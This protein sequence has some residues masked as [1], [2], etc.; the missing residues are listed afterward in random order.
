MLYRLIPLIFFI[1][2]FAFNLN[3]QC[4]IDVLLP[5]SDTT[6]CEGDSVHLN[7]D[8][9]CTFLMNN[10]FDNQTI[11]AGWYSTQANP[12]F[13][14]PCG[15]GPN[16]AHL[17]VGTTNS[18]Q[19]TLVTNNYDVSST[20]CMIKW[21]MRYGEISG[22]GSCEDPDLPDEGVHLQY[23]TNNGATWT[24]F[25]GPDVDPVGVNSF[26]PPFT[27][28]TTTVG[29]GGY[30]E[31]VGVPP[32]PPS[33]SVYY[34]HRYENS[35]PAAAATTNTKFRWAQLSTSNVNYDAWGIDE[36][37]IYCPG[38]Q[39]VAWSH[40]VQAFDG[41]WVSPTS[42]HTYT[43][44]ILDTSGNSASDDVTITVIPTPE[45]G[46]GP[47]TTICAGPNNY[48]V[49]QADSGYDTYLWNTGA[50][51]QSITVS[52]SG[53]YTV[54]VTDGNCSA[55]DSVN[56][57]VAPTPN[58]DAGPD[59]EICFGDSV[60]LTAAAANGSYAWS[61][62]DSI[63]SITVSPNNDT[64]YYLT[65]TSALGCKGYDTV[66]VKVHPLPNADAGPDKEICYGEQVD[67]TA[68]GGQD[69]E[70]SNGDMFATTT[71]S[72][73]NTTDYYVKVTDIH[74]CVN[75]DTTTVTVYPLPVVVASAKDSLICLGDETELYA[76]GAQTYSWNNG[77]TGST[78]TI[79]PVVTKNYIVTGT[80]ADGCS[81][82]DTVKVYTE[83]CS[84][85]FIPNAFS[86]NGDGLNDVF[87]PKGKFEAFKDYE[88]IIYDSFGNIIFKSEDPADG[89]D[90]TINNEPAP[91]DVYIYKIEYT[92]VWNK[93][94][95]KT[96]SV[97]LIR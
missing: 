41:G 57:T 64:D 33:Q 66:T 31:P 18:Q 9:S 59:K 2:G 72:P 24:D 45:P 48:A 5:T 29:S 7:S 73:N 19:R 97:T 65:V 46:L 85:F 20:S 60:T 81:N 87:K 68:S 93:S 54:T 67:L 83:D 88:F 50:T 58:A 70:W 28:N 91:A 25:P 37:E 15:P 47:D 92:S 76:T 49:L 94:F 17:W 22:P 61:T 55:T 32:S 53:I 35:V 16:G 86:P 69:Y 8:G 21:W 62:G 11:G 34:W 71:V 14:N 84:T 51:T 42:T 27:N 30:W 4:N 56:V 44:Y 40:G 26:T 80:D 75:Y 52:N 13:T 77:Q 39:N 90:G 95:T 82:K 10:S 79:S 78:V 23:S 3:S 1:T 43:V 12:V 6:I 63:Q 74:S 96:G 36:V 89:W 38:Q